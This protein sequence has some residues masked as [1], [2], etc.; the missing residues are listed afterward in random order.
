MRPGRKVGRLGQEGRARAL[1]RFRQVLRERA[2]KSSRVRE[3]VA[4]AALAQTGHFTVEE[5]LHALREGGVHEAHM[6]T[7]YRAI[8]LLLDAGLIQP[9]LVL[10]SDSQHYEVVFEREHHDH[11]VCTSCGRVVEYQSAALVALQRKIAA[12]YD[13]ALDEQTS[14]L[15][16]RCKSCRRAAINGTGATPAPRGARGSRAAAVSGS[17]RSAAHP[18]R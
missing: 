17:R 12:R 10:N 18:S 8:P 6:A 9:A 2:L 16:G 15:H 1:D 7:V 4:R 5:L 14:E 13:F 11:L 3:A